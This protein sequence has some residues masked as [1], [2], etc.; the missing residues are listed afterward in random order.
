M[1]QLFC[2]CLSL[3]RYL[4]SYNKTSRRCGC[5]T[6]KK[7]KSP[8]EMKASE[9]S[10]IQQLKD[11]I[12]R[13]QWVRSNPKPP[14]RKAGQLYRCTTLASLNNSTKRR[15]KRMIKQTAWNH[16]S[17]AEFTVYKG[18][19]MGRRVREVLWYSSTVNS[20][21]EGCTSVSDACLCTCKDQVRLIQK[22]VKCYP[23]HHLSQQRWGNIKCETETTL[24]I[25]PIHNLDWQQ[26][27]L[28]FWLVVWK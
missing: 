14:S 20:L 27:V 3:N 25:G 28:A 11:N 13:D 22:K 18:T 6:R 2:Y 23:P 1:K 12:Q 19:L 5:Y 24:Q 10:D 7:E 16:F 4:I 9:G 21:K 15:I 26:I 8:W 17:L